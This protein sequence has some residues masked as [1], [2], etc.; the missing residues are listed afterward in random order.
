MNNFL[1]RLLSLLILFLTTCRSSY[2][3]TDSIS[4]NKYVNAGLTKYYNK[5]YA[6]AIA[7]FDTAVLYNVAN[8]KAYSYRGYAKTKLK[9]YE[10]AIGD[11]NRALA[12]N[13]ND[14]L[15]YKWRAEAKR[16][17][18]NYQPALEDYNTAIRL[19]PKDPGMY[20]GRA[21]IYRGL[22]RLSDAI[23]DYNIY[24]KLRP[25]FS[26]AYL[27]RG[28]VFFFANQYSNAI[29]DFNKY[30][31][32]ENK[33]N[34]DVNL[35]YYRGSS[36]AILKISDSAIADLEKFIKESK[37]APAYT[38]LG[39]AYAQKDDSVTA[40]KNFAAAISLDSTYYEA[41]AQWGFAENQFENHAKAKELLNKVYQN[42]KQ[43]TGYL[44][45][46]L[47]EA[48]SET[49]DID[50]AI[51]HFDKAIEIDSSLSADIYLQRIPLLLSQIQSN[52][53]N[54]LLLHDINALQQLATNKT[55][56]GE[57]YFWKALVKYATDD[58][59]QEM[60]ADIDKAIA[61]APDEPA[62]YMLRSIAVA[63]SANHYKKA[64]ADL[65][66]AIGLNNKMWE[67]Y[68]LKTRIYF[69]LKDF[70]GSCKNIKT[71]SA[72]AGKEIIPEEVVKAYCSGKQPEE[73]FN[74][75]VN[76]V[77]SHSIFNR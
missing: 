17:S 61:L 12:I 65:N 18:S 75:T 8:W 49:N 48:E 70:A 60:P 3:Q 1:Y 13:S 37:F 22:E 52:K 44:L 59:K 69:E 23:S 27:Q 77:P 56:I 68:I 11:Y 42:V 71:A 14:T 28:M 36:Y 58:K 29:N 55:A 64:L 4:S 45:L 62:Y 6:G 46:N 25:D 73:V 66:K 19:D 39:M 5:D 43:P 57:L 16:F 32:L 21:N 35:Y 74:V 33:N 34:V 38:N 15:S 24:I 2:A 53:Y 40:R 31:R 47:A 50:S 30:Q 72:L 41:F 67:P 7:D 54:Q 63:D 10:E 20:F 9:Q 26:T 76:F 51:T